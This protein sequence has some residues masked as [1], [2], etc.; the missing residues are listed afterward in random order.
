MGKKETFLNI[1]ER[2]QIII[3]ANEFTSY[4]KQFGKMAGDNLSLKLVY[5]FNF[6]KPWSISFSC[7]HL[8]MLVNVETLK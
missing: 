1:C 6:Y 2:W 3:I 5:N 8:A 4:N 7:R